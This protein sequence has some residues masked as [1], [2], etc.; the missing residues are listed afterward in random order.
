[1]RNLKWPLFFLLL[2]LA[3]G[4]ACNMPNLAPPADA[5]QAPSAPPA[6][7][8]P[9]APA[10]ASQ[11]Q[12]AAPLDAPVPCAVEPTPMPTLPRGLRKGLAD[13]NS[14]RLST[15]ITMN[16][17]TD[18]DKNTTRTLVEY[19]KESDSLHTRS[20]TTTSSADSP[21]ASA[22]I[23]EQYR[24]DGKTCEFS[25][26]NDDPSGEVEE[27]VAAEQAMFNTIFGLFDFV[28][29][30][31]NPQYVGVDEVNGF[32]THHYTFNVAEVASI[33]GAEI[34]QSSGE[35]WFM[36]EEQTLVRYRAVLEARSEG[37]TGMETMLLQM[38]VNLL[39]ADTPIQIV[40]P[41][42]CQ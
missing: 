16:G 14:Y 27:V 11:E 19:I 12:P 7:E 13:L 41:P 39:E 37:E 26:T 22:E 5:P 18:L 28:V 20:E 2:W 42:E 8:Q 25:P 23:S 15:E 1:M 24:V 33:P 9:A 10:E 35:Y 29:F 21:E 4:L 34:T 30:A 32:Q 17:P 6:G 36:V 3:V 38:E 40:M 31:E